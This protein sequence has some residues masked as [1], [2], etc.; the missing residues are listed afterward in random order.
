MI[1]KMNHPA[2]N[3]I[4]LLLV[5]TCNLALAQYRVIISSDFPAIP[6]TNSDPDDVQSMVRFLL[7]SNE[8]DVEGLIASAATFGMTAPAN[9]PSTPGA[10]NSS[11]N[12]SNA[13]TGWCGKGGT[14]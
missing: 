4:A 8:F 6:V 1:G 10:P 11:P 12:S 7:Y 13:P 14:Y 2:R 3:F 5:L 9:Q